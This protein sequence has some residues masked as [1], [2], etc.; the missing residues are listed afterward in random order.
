[1]VV[2]GEYFI[3]VGDTKS[4]CGSH[5]WGTAL[6][7]SVLPWFFVF[8]MMSA[9]LKIFPGWLTPF[10][11]T[12]GYVVVR[13]FGLSGLVRTIFKPSI[14]D[15]SDLKSI[16]G[17]LAYIYSDQSLIVNEITPENFDTF[18]KK[19]TPLL[20]VNVVKNSDIKTKLYNLI[21][22]KFLVSQYIWYVLTGIL[23]ASMSYNYIAGSAC[24]RSV[25]EMQERAN[26][27]QS[28]EEETI[29]KEYI[30]YD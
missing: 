26:N 18:W 12:F 3:A 24:K 17:T 19:V 30:S 25:K 16:Q 2:I 23:V 20:K 6:M 22:I 1:M 14:D 8:G 29:E 11:N 27:I 4:L 28:T 5:Q 21:K 13:M 9:L 15:D 7:A 10:S